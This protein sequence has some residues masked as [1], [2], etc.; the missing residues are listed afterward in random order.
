[1]TEQMAIKIIKQEEQWESNSSIS[2]AFIMAIQ[3]L[4]EIQQYRAIGTVEEIKKAIMLF[5]NDEDNTIIDDLNLLIHYKLLGTIEELQALKEKS[6]KGLLLELPCKVG[7]TVWCIVSA[8][9]KVVECT[10][11]WIEKHQNGVMVFSLDGGLGDVVLAHLG[12]KWFL[13][14]EEA[15]K[16]L[17]NA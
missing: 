1:M 17:N 9:T 11:L 12:E 16:K 15:E 4:E 13:T 14:K 6:E 2:K 3:A 8:G 10:V 5:S 7:D